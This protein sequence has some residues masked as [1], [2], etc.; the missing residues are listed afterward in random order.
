MYPIMSKFEIHYNK[1]KNTELFSYFSDLSENKIK[2]MQNYIPIYSKFFS[3]KSNNYN[4]INLNH[5]YSIEKI[6]EIHGENDFS[7][8]VK[9][10]KEQHNKKSFFKYSPLLDTSKF[11]VGKYKDISKNVL[12]NLP[13]ITDNKET[14]LKKII[15][16]DNS[17]YT[18]SFFSYLSSKTLHN[19]G[20]VHGIDFYGSF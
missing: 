14:V 15:C 20:F 5:H 8:F 4:D 13:K 18:D 17:A 6:K 1:K 11:M 7:I 12:E 19:H 9:T 3:L 10:D 16:Q 2:N